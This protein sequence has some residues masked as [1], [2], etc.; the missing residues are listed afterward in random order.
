LQEQGDALEWK[1]LFRLCQMRS[2]LEIHGSFFRW[3][4]VLTFALI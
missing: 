1:T 4:S 2:G 3:S